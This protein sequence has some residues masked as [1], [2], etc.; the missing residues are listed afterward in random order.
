MKLVQ[1]L[2]DAKGRDIVTI[3]PQAS[4]LEAIRLMAERGIGSLLV[5]QGDALAGIVTRSA[6]TRAKSSSRGARRTVPKSAK[7]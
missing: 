6:T 4:V 1:H 7:S 5:M 3:A 2:L